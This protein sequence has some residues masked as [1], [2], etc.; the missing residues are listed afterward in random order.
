MVKYPPPKGNIWLN[1][2]PL[3]KDDLLGKVVLFDFWTYSCVNCLRTLPH[4]KRWWE[5][6]KNKDFLIVGIHTPEFE[7]EKERAN[8]EPA[9]QEFGISWPVV[10]DN[11]YQNWRNFVNRYWPAKYLADQKGNII[12]SHFGEGEYFLTE[13]KIRE[14][15]KNNLGPKAK[16]PKLKPVDSTL[17]KV[18]CIEPTPELYCGYKRGIFAN[19]GEYQYDAAVDFDAP[20]TMPPNSIAFEGK[21]MI[22]PEYAEALEHGAKIWLNFQA[23][24]VNLVMAPV[25]WGAVLD[26]ELDGSPLSG[27]VSGLNVNPASK[28]EIYRPAMY[29]IVRSNMPVMGILKVIVFEWSPPFR[30]YAFTFSGCLG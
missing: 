18:S 22:G 23:T 30:A 21:F 17:E 7:F 6:Y 3:K 4:L 11:D 25:S 2:R 9:L 19:V 20:E 13:M 15:I 28:V 27:T 24:E 16:L 14:A 10:L 5:K 1:S 8:V 12:Y 26:L 29:N